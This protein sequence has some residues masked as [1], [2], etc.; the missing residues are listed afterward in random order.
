MRR[1]LVIARDSGN[2]FNE[3][4]VAQNLAGVEVQ[5]GDPLTALDYL[6][7]A[8]RNLHDSGNTSVIRSPIGSSGSRLPNWR[9]GSCAETHSPCAYRLNDMRAGA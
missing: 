3:W 2:H 6:K 5:H 9:R 8:I 7:L 1:A 4:N